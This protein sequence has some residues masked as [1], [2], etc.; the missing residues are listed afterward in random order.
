[1]FY[2]KAGCIHKLLINWG[3]KN[4]DNVC[5]LVSTQHKAN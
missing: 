1:M 2:S 5:A 3:K 4:F